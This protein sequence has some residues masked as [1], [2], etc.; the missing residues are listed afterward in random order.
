MLLFIVKDLANQTLFL[1]RVPLI[2]KDLIKA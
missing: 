1:K 2:F